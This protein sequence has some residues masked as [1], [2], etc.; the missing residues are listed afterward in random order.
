MWFAC[1][2]LNAAL[3]DQTVTFQGKQVSPDGIVSQFQLSG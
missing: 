3:L 1:T 2:P